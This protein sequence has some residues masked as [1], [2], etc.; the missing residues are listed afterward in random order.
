MDPATI[1]ISD[2]AHSLSLICRYNGHCRNFYSVAEHCV[3]VAA[4]LPDEL[5]LMG[6]MHDA[7]EAYVGDVCQP[8]KSMLP[9]YKEIENAVEKVI[10]KKF[11]KRE[12]TSEEHIAI[13]A[14][15]NKILLK[16]TQEMMPSKGAGW[17]IWTGANWNTQIDIE[18]ECWHPTMAEAL[19]IKRWEELN[20]I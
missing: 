8:L 1:N 2:I 18:I 9:K 13:K 16:E 19:F 14:A 5:K 17:N 15:D 4:I 10:F 3:H 7:T 20:E 11:F 6:L 12:L